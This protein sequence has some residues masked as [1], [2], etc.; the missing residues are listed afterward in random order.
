MLSIKRGYISCAREIRQLAAFICRYNP[1][2]QAVSEFVRNWGRGIRRPISAC[3][4]TRITN[5]PGSDSAAAGTARAPLIHTTIVTAPPNLKNCAPGTGSILPRAVV[6]F[7]RG[8]RD[9]CPLEPRALFR[10]LN[11]YSSLFRYLRSSDECPWAGLP[12]VA[13]KS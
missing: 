6:P 13:T 9:H 5:L 12:R 1:G 8:Q 4:L 2:H 10:S 11:T 7:L 3:I